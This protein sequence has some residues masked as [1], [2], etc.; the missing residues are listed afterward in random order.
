M[1][2]QNFEIEIKTLDKA[3]NL[4]MESAQKVRLVYYD[5]NY[6]NFKN[7]LEESMKRIKQEQQNLIKIRSELI[8]LHQTD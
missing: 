7:P 3:I 5:I 2:K 8:R 1:E 6:E 4:L